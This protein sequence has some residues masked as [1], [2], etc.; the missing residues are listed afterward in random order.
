MHWRQRTFE[1]D[2]AVIFSNQ[3]LLNA[4]C[5]KWIKMATEHTEV[6]SRHA[7]APLHT[8]QLCT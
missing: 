7:N 6:R 5:C 8:L 1:D 4:G 2:N 3:Y